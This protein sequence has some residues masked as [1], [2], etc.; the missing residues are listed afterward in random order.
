M[1]NRLYTGYSLGWVSHKQL[2]YEVLALRGDVFEFLVLKVEFRLFYSF[3][4]FGSI[5]VLERQ[6]ARDQHIEEHS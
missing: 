5:W 2:S 3:E 4:N 6:I 1:F